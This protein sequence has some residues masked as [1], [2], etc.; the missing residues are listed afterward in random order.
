[1]PKQGRPYADDMPA[2]R[3]HLGYSPTKPEV[4]Y[5]DLER[6]VRA[7]S[8]NDHAR[9]LAL[10]HDLCTKVR[11]LEYELDQLRRGRRCVGASPASGCPIRPAGFLEG[12][13]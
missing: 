8:Y 13:S 6:Y 9:V 12:A 10:I 11:Q 4:T 3:P 7:G 5:Q 1:M 2:D